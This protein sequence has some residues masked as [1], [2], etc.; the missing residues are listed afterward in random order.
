VRWNHQTRTR[1]N[2]ENTIQQA[3]TALA[4]PLRAAITTTRTE[5]EVDRSALQA[6][7][8]QRAD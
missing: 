1:M 3:Y 8:S 4:R 7:A 6:A 5:V 2:A